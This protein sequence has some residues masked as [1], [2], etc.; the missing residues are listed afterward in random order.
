MKKLS[1][2]IVANL[3]LAGMGIAGIMIF[4]FLVLAVLVG[5]VS[6]FYGAVLYFAW[7]YLVVDALK[8]SPT[9]LSYWTCYF[10]CFAISMLKNI[11]F[12]D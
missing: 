8:I 4:V 5:I 10:I 6:F 11:I 12:G 7:N 2:R 1:G 3:G 9:H